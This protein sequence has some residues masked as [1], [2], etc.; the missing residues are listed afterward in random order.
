VIGSF[1]SITRKIYRLPARLCLDNFLRRSGK[2][3]KIAIH[4]KLME[5]ANSEEMKDLKKFWFLYETA[6]ALGLD[7]HLIKKG[8]S[9]VVDR[10]QKLYLLEQQVGPIGRKDVA[11]GNEWLW[12]SLLKDLELQLA[13]KIAN[14]RTDFFIKLCE[15]V[16]DLKKFQ[17]SRAF[18][19]YQL[20]GNGLVENCSLIVF[21]HGFH[22]LSQ[23]RIEYFKYIQSWFGVNQPYPE[24]ADIG[25]QQFIPSGEI[26]VSSADP[27]LMTL[28]EYFFNKTGRRINEVIRFKARPEHITSIDEA[29]MLISGTMLTFYYPHF[30]PIECSKNISLITSKPLSSMEREFVLYNE[31]EKQLIP[32]KGIG[33]YFLDRGYIIEDWHPSILIKNAKKLLSVS[34]A[35]TIILLTNS[36]FFRGEYSPKSYLG[37]YK[38]KVHQGLFLFDSE[39]IEWAKYFGPDVYFIVSPNNL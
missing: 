36:I 13:K 31:G 5:L 4:E 3:K 7:D 16:S 29:S 22:S 30:D 33:Q 28:E 14:L 15:E 17:E 23:Y 24:I 9:S 34:G 27:R 32:K 26:P 35:H 19:E 11:K 6:E 10:Y 37:I 12:G 39:E 21:Q 20:N 8:H 2:S 18:K 25:R 1:L 38:N